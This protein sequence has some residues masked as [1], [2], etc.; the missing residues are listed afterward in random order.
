MKKYK[1]LMFILIT[2]IGTIVLS[3]KVLSNNNNKIYNTAN[4]TPYKIVCVNSIEVLEKIPEYIKAKKELEKIIANHQNSLK[5][6]NNEIEMLLFNNKKSYSDFKSNL[7]DLYKKREKLQQMITN[8]LSNKEKEL[9]FPVFQKFDLALKNIMNKDK[10]IMRID[11]SS[12]GKGILINIGPD[13][14]NQ[15]KKELKIN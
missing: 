2:S 13:I 10:T 7:M 3:N 5:E 15:V 8:D 9:L 6:I 1:I 14:T 11:D 12:P 4:I